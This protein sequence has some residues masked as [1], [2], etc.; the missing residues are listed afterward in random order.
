MKLRKILYL[1]LIS[2]LLPLGALATGMSGTTYQIPFDS[3]NI[4]G[5][6]FS[7]SPNYMMSDTMG[8]VAPGFS[9]SA[10]YG[11][12]KAGYRQPDAAIVTTLT[13]VLSTSNL[14]LGSIRPN[15][16]TAGDLITTVTTNA[17]NGY[18]LY[19]KQNQLL[20]SGSY[21]IPNYSGTISTPTS[22]A[23]NGFGFTL[24]SGTG[25][26]AKWGSGSNYAGLPLA[27]TLIHAKAGFSVLPNDTGLRFN[28]Q[29]GTQ[30][31]GI[32]SNTVTFTALPKL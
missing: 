3:I 22:W 24:V 26:D 6:D 17:A 2:A 28:V 25:L 16:S 31:Q 21:T 23:G 7:T 14:N 20:T 5:S 15:E 27:S 12:Q 30:A 8:E 32:Y 10:N 9:S 19:I 1:F 13:L 18:E 11:M 4:G 29:V